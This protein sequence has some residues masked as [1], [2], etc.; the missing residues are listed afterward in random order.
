MQQVSQAWKDNQQQI[1]VGEGYVE[2]SLNIADPESVAD[3]SSEDNGEIYISDSSTIVS[4]IDKDVI[5]YITTE[6]NIWVLDG[7]MIPISTTETGDIGYVGDILSE[8]DNRFTDKIPTITINFTE[9]HTKLV[10]GVTV[11]WGSA[12]E[13]FATDFT[14]TVY[15]GDTQV[16]QKA[17]T[18]NRNVS[19]VV[20]MELTGYDRIVIQINRW[21]LPLH[22][23]RIKEIFVGIEKVYTRDELF[24]YSHTQNADPIT[25]S[26]PK[27]E[28]SFSID[29]RANEYN[30][31]NP[32]GLTKYL[33][34]RQEVYSRYGF[35]L[36]DGTVEW[37]NGGTF[38]LSEWDSDQNGISASFKARDL[39]EYMNGTYYKG[40]YAP[41]GASLYNLATDII[42]QA[43]LPYNSDGSVKWQIDDSLKSIYTVAPLPIDTLAN[44]LQLIANAAGCA[45]YQDRMGILH[46]SPME[47]PDTD[48]VISD[49]NS[50]SKAE[51]T[52]SKPIKEIDV[53]VYSYFT[54]E[55]VE[56]YKGVMQLSGTTE[57]VITYSENALD[58]EATVTGGT[59]VSA[60]YYTGACVLKIAAEGEASV[61]VTGTAL[62]DS[63]AD[64]VLPVG[65]EGDT[66]TLSNPLITSRTMASQ[67]GTAAKWHYQNRRTLKSSWRADPRVDVLD[68]VTNSNEFGSNSVVLTSVD[69]R[70]NGAFRG[71][72]E[73]RVM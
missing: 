64:V 51:L 39:L 66:L 56:L 7:N 11:V 2:V 46:I 23:P 38:Y 9:A 49:S 71:N 62:K 53:E 19:S 54:G 21:C 36:P 68:K 72:A 26:L 4:E 31:H 48:Y 65:D 14:I 41:T 55:S 35:K 32:V 18:G 25:A 24:S 28:I 37:I 3:A 20:E 70:Y 42:G 22:R 34:E 73:G 33:M 13:E 15:N 16:L 69:F 10:P 67:L 60:Q 45:L 29:N 44:C 8:D 30:P 61:T 17:V 1:I 59:L 52:L 27:M 5:P 43:N 12:Y 58:A 57:M 63:T 50:Y 40:M 47:F 6:Q